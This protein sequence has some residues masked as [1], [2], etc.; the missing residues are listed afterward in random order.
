MDDKDFKILF[1]NNLKRI[2]T[3]KGIKQ[4]ILAEK[5]G[6]EDHNL[7]RIETGYSF[8]RIKTLVK[9]FD[10]LNVEPVEFFKFIKD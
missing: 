2:R 5:I 6:I 8:P 10:S 1:G 7:S 9:I 3:K 4:S